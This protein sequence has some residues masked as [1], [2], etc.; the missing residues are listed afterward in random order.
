[1][2][3]PFS[4]LRFINVIFY[5]VVV[6]L[7]VGSSESRFTDPISHPASDN[8]YSTSGLA[9]SLHRLRSR[10]YGNTRLGGTNSLVSESAAEIRRRNARL[11]L[12][13]RLSNE[14]S[15][16]VMDTNDD[17]MNTNAPRPIPTAPLDLRSSHMHRPNQFAS[18]HP[19]YTRQTE[20]ST[21]TL[22]RS[23]TMGTLTESTSSDLSRNNYTISSP[24]HA[25][26][27]DASAA[28]VGSQSHRRQWDPPSEAARRN[29]P[30]RPPSHPSFADRYMNHISSLSNDF[31]SRFSS[32]SDMPDFPADLGDRRRR[33][34]LLLPPRRPTLPRPDLGVQF[35][36]E[37]RVE[38]SPNPVTENLSARSA[39]RA[40][41]GESRTGFR[42]AFRSPSPDE[43]IPSPMFLDRELQR[44]H[45]TSSTSNA[46]PS[47]GTYGGLDPSNYHAGPFRDTIQRL[48]NM[49]R[50]RTGL[51]TGRPDSIRGPP[52]PSL[53]PLRFED[54]FSSLQTAPVPESRSPS[55]V[56]LF[57]S[58]NFFYGT[59]NWPFICLA[60]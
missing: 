38:S 41:M 20:T 59:D 5:T 45:D 54:D 32:V 1:M 53:P 30:V 23:R 42:S 3:S 22:N 21:S 36:Y 55:W 44:P 58:L 2:V 35:S 60:F 26:T 34:E 48:V 27:T 14:A 12:M 31:D 52:P 6:L 29:G 57:L 7:D 19:F 49:E 9:P 51:A 4:M 10:L 24:Y 25:P 8:S 47:T 43:R 15:E 16:H 17:G 18:D 28:S 33:G 50:M 46:Q 56:C 40:S 37:D 39:L 11:E 13:E